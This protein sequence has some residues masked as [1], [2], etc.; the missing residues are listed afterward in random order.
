M[1]VIRTKISGQCHQLS[2][3]ET[4]QF[5]EE[6]TCPGKRTIALLA[7]QSTVHKL[8]ITYPNLPPFYDIFRRNNIKEGNEVW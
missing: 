3:K 8:I 4:P 2:E 5:T 7:F 6:F 1:I